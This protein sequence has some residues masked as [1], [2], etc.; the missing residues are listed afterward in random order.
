MAAFFIYDDFN[1]KWQDEGIVVGNKPFGESSIIVTLL[2]KNHGLQKGFIKTTKQLKNI[3]I[4]TLV[5]ASWKARLSEQLG[6]FTIEAIDIPFARLI[7]HPQKI[8][9][10]KSLVEIIQIV[11]PEHHPYQLLYEEISHFLK[12]IH[13]LNTNIFYQYCY[14]EFLLIKELGYGFDFSQCCLCESQNIDIFYISPKTGKGACKKCGDPFASKLFSFDVGVFL[15]TTED[16]LIYKQALAV[17]GYFLSHHIIKQINEKQNLPS[18][19]EHIIE[20]LHK[21]VV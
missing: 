20:S 15:T 14:L 21:L 16:P 6:T 8:I 2:T 11:L 17:S 3:Q 13:L 12:K 1:M 5:N 19:R 7:Q 4:G 18:I 10:L 9:F